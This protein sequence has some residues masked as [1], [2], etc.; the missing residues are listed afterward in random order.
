MQGAPEGCSLKICCYLW[1]YTAIQDAEDLDTSVLHWSKPP[2]A[3]AVCI[4]VQ[5]RLAKRV[6]HGFDLTTNEVFPHVGSLTAGMGMRARVG[7]E[8]NTCSATSRMY[9]VV[10][11]VIDVRIVMP[12]LI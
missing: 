12:R 3:K 10:Q 9:F 1:A 4:M 2:E 11:D 8:T 7:A 6:V 5:E